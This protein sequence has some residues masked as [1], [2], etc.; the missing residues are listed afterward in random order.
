LIPNRHSSTLARMYGM[1]SS[2]GPCVGS[3]AGMGVVSLVDTTA[4]YVTRLEKVTRDQS[5][6]IMKVPPV[7]SQ[8]PPLPHP[9]WWRIGPGVVTHLTP[10]T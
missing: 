10:N 4:G 5:S 2:W 6:K 1:N 8:R 3:P 9:G 7:P